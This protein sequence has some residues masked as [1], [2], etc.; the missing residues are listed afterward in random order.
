MRR[1]LTLLLLLVLTLGVAAGPHPCHAQAGPSLPAVTGHASCHGPQAAPKA[2]SRPSHDC[3]D[4][5]KG[6][7]VLCDQ[8][9]QGVALMVV[10][11]TLP[12]ILA[13]REPELPAVH[14]SGALCVFAIDH[15]PWSETQPFLCFSSTLVASSTLAGRCVESTFFRSF[16]P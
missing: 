3:C 11:P 14:R 1:P 5:Q 12:E 4:P 9:C 10:A 7:H 6:G 16:R 2:P 8:A 15:V 13:F